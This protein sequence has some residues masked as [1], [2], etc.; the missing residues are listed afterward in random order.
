[1]AKLP[2]SISEKEKELLI[3]VGLCI[4][5]WASVDYLLL[6]LTAQ[7]LEV[8]SGRAAIVHQRTPT[9]DGRITLIDELGRVL[10]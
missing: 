10:K 3:W 8:G 2:A 9:L 6:R 5:E 7:V 4:T 1:M